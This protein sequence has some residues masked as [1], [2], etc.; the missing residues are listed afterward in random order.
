MKNSY[1]R[2]PC[3]GC[4]GS[5]TYPFR[6]VDE[7]CDNCKRLMAEALAHREKVK[8][9]PGSMKIRVGEMYHWNQGYYE[10]DISG[11]FGNRSLRDALAIMMVKLIKELSE[12]DN[13]SPYESHRSPIIMKKLNCIDRRY[14]E[15]EMRLI[16]KRLFGLLRGLDRLI[17]F[18]I[19]RSYKNGKREGASLIRMLASGQITLDEFERQVEVD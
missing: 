16:N 14:E 2:K 7:V 8:N 15:N 13:A 1:T 6:K 19:R 18:A 12:I 3:P 5:H 17:R 9:I 4:G 11:K 10:G